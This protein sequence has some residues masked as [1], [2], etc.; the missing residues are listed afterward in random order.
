MKY[1]NIKQYNFSSDSTGDDNSFDEIICVS[2]ICLLFI[3]F[4]IYGISFIYIIS[5]MKRKTNR[6][7]FWKVPL[8]IIAFPNIYFLTGAIGRLI[9]YL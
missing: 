6:S 2:G 3:D 9:A 1:L 8:L 7:T 5:T 4:I